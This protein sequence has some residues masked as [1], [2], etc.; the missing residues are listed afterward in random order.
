MLCPSSSITFQ[1]NALHLSAIGADI[2]AS[3]R[4][5]WFRDQ[6]P[7]RFYNMGIAEQNQ[8]N[9]AAGMSLMGKV[10]FVT[11]YGVFLA[12]RSWDQIRTTICYNNLNVKLGGAH[13]G[14]S[15][16]PDGATHQALEEIAI[17]R[18]VGATNHFIRMPFIVE[19]LVLGE[20]AAL[21][22]F[23]LDFVVYNYLA[24]GFINATGLVELVSFSTF[25]V[26]L[27]LIV[28]VA[29][30]VVGVG[31]SVLTIRKFLKV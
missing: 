28:L 15:V 9:V 17:M 22:A 18:M 14:I 1:L 29:G 13:G 11:N 10:P 31:G 16:G 3:T 12:G 24:E 20:I 6:F 19:G 30:L 2:T 8:M 27:L 4:V 26:P 7:E 5:D 23:G 25:A 21:L